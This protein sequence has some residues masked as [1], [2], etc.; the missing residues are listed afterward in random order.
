MQ[1]DLT[2]TVGN[3]AQVVLKRL[4]GKKLD[5]S[6]WILKNRKEKDITDIHLLKER[7]AIYQKLLTDLGFEEM[8]DEI[9]V[10]DEEE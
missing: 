1:E 8:P 4:L 2:L 10:G 5:N 9:T 6:M 3:D 7:I